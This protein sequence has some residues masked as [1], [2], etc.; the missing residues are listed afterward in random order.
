MI[1]NEDLTKDIVT[2][3]LKIKGCALP[4]AS[5]VLR[6]KNPNIYQIIDQRVFRIVTGKELRMN[7]Q[8][9]KS[10]LLVGKYIEYLAELR[11]ACQ[12]IDI[13]FKES[14]RIL[15]NVDRRINKSIPIKY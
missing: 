8:S 13:D 1:L 14:D 7:K 12:R 3:L 9:Q 2:S 5:T 4:M 11:K 10:E 15:F 6:F